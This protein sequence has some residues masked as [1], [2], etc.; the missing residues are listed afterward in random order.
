MM[1]MT[2]LRIT[3]SVR[4]FA[5][6][7]PSCLVLL[8]SLTIMLHQTRSVCLAI[9][10]FHFTDGSLN[11]LADAGVQAGI[12]SCL[13]YEVTD[14]NGLD[15]ATAGITENIAFIKYAPCHHHHH[16]LGVAMTTHLRY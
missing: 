11:V 15:G 13:C 2:S 4:W 16:I 1:V 6:K 8:Q 5:L 10:R 14:R 3:I 9:V 7:T 12:R